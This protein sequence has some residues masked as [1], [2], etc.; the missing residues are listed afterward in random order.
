MNAEDYLKHWDKNQV[1]THYSWPKHKKRFQTIAVRLDGKS[2]IDIGCGFGHSTRILSRCY[3]ARWAGV[4]FLFGAIERARRLFPGLEFIHAPDYD[5]LT[6]CG[7]RKFDSV[8]CSEVIE[9]I[10]DD[11]AFVEQLMKITGTKLVVTTPN[12]FVDD[13]GHLRVYTGEMFEDLFEGFKFTVK[14]IG[15]YYYIE[16]RP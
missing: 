8:V 14:S 10:E 12:R 2:C 16:V 13:P 4:E 3:H 6:A 1:W 11:R 9:H 15:G 7:G 5:L